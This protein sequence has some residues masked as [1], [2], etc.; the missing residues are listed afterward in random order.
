MDTEVILGVVRDL[1][2]MRVFWI[3]L[4]GGEPLLNEDLATI[5]E[6]IGDETVQANCSRQVVA[7]PESLQVT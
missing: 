4:T 7:L 5:V 1:K 2:N 3:G 6:S